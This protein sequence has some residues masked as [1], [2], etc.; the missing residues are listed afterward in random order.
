LEGGV[1]AGD[2][3]DA[4]GEVVA[5]YEGDVVEDLLVAD[6]ACEVEF[7]EGDGGVTLFHYISIMFSGLEEGGLTVTTQFSTPLQSPVSHAAPPPLFPPIGLAPV[8]PTLK[9]QF[10]RP[11]TL[12]CQSA[13]TDKC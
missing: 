9:L 8:P 6:A 12:P 10:V 13:L 2:V 11:H 3:D 5:V 1:G 4:D 7:G